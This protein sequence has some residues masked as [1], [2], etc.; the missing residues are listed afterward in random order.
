[1]TSIEYLPA[2]AEWL[3]GCV[4]DLPRVGDP[5][6]GH[7]LELAGWVVGRHTPVATVEILH[8]THWLT[9]TPVLLV[10][11]DVTRI[12]SSPTRHCAHG[13]SG[14]DDSPSGCP[15][16]GAGGLGRVSHGRSAGGIPRG[17]ARAHA[18][19]VAV[20][21]GAAAAVGDGARP[22]SATR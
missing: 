10:R 22:V 8:D 11:P 12:W 6:D 17:T 20:P 13:L 19:A 2:A 21:A 3:S 14:G 5:A 7:V 9:G 15:R 4:I 16:A 1:M 18:A